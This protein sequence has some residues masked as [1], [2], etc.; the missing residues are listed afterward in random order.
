MII[1]INKIEKDIVKFS[2]K[3]G[4]AY[5]IWKDNLTPDLK[6]YGV[7]LDYDKILHISQLNLTDVQSP[8]MK[9]NRDGI[10]IIGKV[11]DVQEKCM[12]FQIGESIIEFEIYNDKKFKK[13]ND[14]FIKISLPYIN[15]YNENIL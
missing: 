13:M 7:E 1:T 12:T 5:G 6:R 10:E 8:R 9:M 4:E 2:S 11:I 14:K 3:Y 15:I